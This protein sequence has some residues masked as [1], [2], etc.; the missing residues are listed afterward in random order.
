MVGLETRAEARPL[1]GPVGQVALAG[2][3]QLLAMTLW[4][5]A[6][7]VLPSLQAAWDLGP[8]GQAWLTAAAQGLVHRRR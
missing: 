3:A 2:V 7:A 5:S 1:G 8:D 4:F 6:T